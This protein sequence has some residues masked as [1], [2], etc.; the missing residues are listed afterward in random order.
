[1]NREFLSK[2]RT[3]EVIKKPNTW[4]ADELVSHPS[5]RVKIYRNACE[6]FEVVE[7]IVQEQTLETNLAIESESKGH[8]V[9]EAGDLAHKADGELL[10]M[11]WN[12]NS[13]NSKLDREHF[14]QYVNSKPFDIICF[15]ETKY[16]EKKFKQLKIEKHPLWHGKYHQYWHFSTKKLGYSGVAVL[17]R[18]KPIACRFG[19]DSAFDCEGRAVT[20]EFE[21][22]YLVCVYAPCSGIALERLAFRVENWEEPL[23]RHLVM[24]KSSKPVIIVGDLNVAH[25]ELDVDNIRK[26]QNFPGFAYEERMSFEILLKSGFIDAYRERHPEKR[27]YSWWDPRFQA[28]A[29]NDGWRL[30][31]CVISEESIGR[32]KDVSLRT[33]VFG[34]DHC[35][36]EVRFDSG[37][38]IKTNQRE[39]PLESTERTEQIISKD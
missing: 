30:D 32:I 13:L 7:S 34:S 26:A 11:M 23:R 25:T 8:F 18:F 21:G 5:K 16:S 28:R 27:E 38:K 6:E 12:V 19:F 14:I 36:L 3:F 37:R 39:N 15:N 20:L 9:H 24:L 4:S 1:M 22:F 33:D 17:T 31:Y 29:K 35:P 2:I 10:I